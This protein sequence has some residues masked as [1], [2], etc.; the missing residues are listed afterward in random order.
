MSAYYLLPNLESDKVEALKSLY[1]E[2]K[3]PLAESFRRR[4]GVNTNKRLSQYRTTKWFTWN[5]AQRDMFRLNYP[6]RY[7]S[8]SIVSYF[9]EFPKNHGFMDRMTTWVGDRHCGTIIAYALND[10]QHILINDQKVTLNKGEGMVFNLKHIHEVK[11]STINS[12]W[13][14]VMVMQPAEDFVD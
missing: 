9:I 12:L 6:E 13:A 4:R 5:Q 10:G 1:A 2:L 7:H 8:K 11:P 3:P 14:N